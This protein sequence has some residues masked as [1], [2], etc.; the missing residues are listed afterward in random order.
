MYFADNEH[1]QNY[2]ALMKLYDLIPGS[3]KQYE[4]NIYIASYPAIF[5]GLNIEKIKTHEGG[6]LIFLHFDEYAEDHKPRVLTGSTKCHY[7]TA[8]KLA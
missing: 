3:D 6:P 5:D 7:T 2:E 4:A 1:A 8:I